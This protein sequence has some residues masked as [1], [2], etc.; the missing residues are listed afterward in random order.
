M[1]NQHIC[2]NRKVQKIEKLFYLSTIEEQIPHTP[3]NTLKKLYGKVLK[4]RI[5]N[6]CNMLVIE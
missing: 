3:A 6:K 1:E 2:V 5:E 4:N